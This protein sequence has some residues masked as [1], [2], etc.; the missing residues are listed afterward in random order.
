MVTVGWSVSIE[1][2]KTW[3]L[4]SLPPCSWTFQSTAH[5]F[6][7]YAFHYSYHQDKKHLAKL[8]PPLSQSE[9]DVKNTKKFVQDFKRLHVLEA[10]YKLISFNVSTLF[11]NVPLYTLYCHVLTQ[12]ETNITKK[13]L[14]DLLIFCTKN[15]HFIINGQLYLQK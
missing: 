6:H 8:A 14:K 1:C 7:H 5:L 13:E 10:N 12:I 4:T 2:L 11:T 9:Y 3:Q 15:I